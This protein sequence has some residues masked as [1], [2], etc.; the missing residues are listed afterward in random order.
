MLDKV[1]IVA[2]WPKTRSL[3]SYVRE[4]EE[5]AALGFLINFRVANLPSWSD[6]ILN[7]CYPRCYMVHDG[8]VRGYNYIKEARYHPENTVSRVKNDAWAGF[9]P[10]GKYIVRYPEWHEIEPIPMKGFQGWCWYYGNAF[11]QSL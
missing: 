6:E 3:E 11:T 7:E 2:T 10:A 5:A 8:Y 9:W 4:L 1:D